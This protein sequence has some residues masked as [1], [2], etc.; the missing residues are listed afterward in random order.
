M[1]KSEDFLSPNL[2]YKF[3]PEKQDQ[4]FAFVEKTGN[5]TAGA[6][7]VGVSKAAVFY[8]VNKDPA[9][10]KRLL[11]AR[12]LAVARLEQ[13]AVRRAVEGVDRPIYQQGALVGVERVYSDNLLLALLKANDPK[14]YG[15]D[16]GDGGGG[17]VVNIVSMD[18]ERTKATIEVKAQG[19]ALPALPGENDFIPD[20]QIIDAMDQQVQ[21]ANMSEDDDG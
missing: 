4:F 13:E 20:S 6:R 3:T 15:R 21:I 1:T 11:E 14:K 7:H 9:F 5:V 18:P 10:A 2:K 17:L 16:G 19:G 8:R 12:E